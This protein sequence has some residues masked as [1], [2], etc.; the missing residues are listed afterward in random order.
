MED[1]LQRPV[2]EQ[3]TAI[4][5]AGNRLIENADSSNNLVAGL[6]IVGLAIGWLIA[7]IISNPVTDAVRYR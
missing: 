1:I 4:T 6:L 3:E 2:E 7:G 5:L